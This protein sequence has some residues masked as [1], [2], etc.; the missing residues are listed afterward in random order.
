MTTTTTEL[1]P[2]YL[3]VTRL[4]VVSFLARYREPT[5]TAYTQDLKAFLG[6]CQTY[7]REALRSAAANSSCMCGT[8]RVGGMRPRRWPVGSAPWP[9]STSTRSSTVSSRPTQRRP[10]PARRWRGRGR[11]APWCTRREFAALLAPARID[12]GLGASQ[13]PIAER[14]RRPE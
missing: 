8:W 6:W 3:D 2:G 12:R 9:R 1:V 13:Q 7:D 5:L 14:A 10:C 4:A 11:S